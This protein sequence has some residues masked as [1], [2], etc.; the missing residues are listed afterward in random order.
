MSDEGKEQCQFYG[1]YGYFT[2]TKITS[3]CCVDVYV[4][5]CQLNYNV[6]A[7]VAIHMKNY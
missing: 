1:S 2:N 6:I 4:S 5:L 3:S 7:L